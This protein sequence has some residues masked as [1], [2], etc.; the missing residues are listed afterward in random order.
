MNAKNDKIDFSETLFLPKTSFAMRAGL[1]EQ[2]PKIL[3][4]W[5][6]TN[7]YHQLRQQSQDRKK[8]ILHDGPPYANGHLHMGHALN[9]ILK[10]FVIRSQQMLGN[11]SSYIP[12]WDCHGLP[13]EW[14]IE[15]QYR[16]NG[17]N[18]D[19]V[20]IIQFR[21]ECRE[22][23]DK[24]IN[25]QR[26]EFIRLGINGDWFSPYTTMSY[27][28]ESIIVKEFFKFLE[29]ESLYRGSKPV[30]WSTV[31]KTALAEAEIEYKE[32]KST[33][34][35]VKFP[36][37]ECSDK[38]FQKAAVV[39]WTT[40]P[41]TIPGNRAIAYSAEINYS[42]Y[43]VESI[44][45]HS[46]LRV[47]DQIIFADE[48]LENVKTQCKLLDL[49]KISEVKDFGSFICDHPFRKSGY[50]F[51]VKLYD[52]DFVTLEQGTGFVHIAPGHG[53]DDYILGIANNIDVP[54][55]VDENGEYFDH[56]PLFNGK[57]IFNEDGSDA[58]ANIAVIIELKKHENLA[59]KGS[60]R[61]S[62][63]HSWRSKAPVIFRNTPQWFISMEKNQLRDKALKEIE[64][65]KWYPKQ[66]KN[67]IYSMIEERPDWVVS[68]QRAWGVPLSIFYNIKTGKPLV[69]KEMNDRI[70]ELYKKE[71]SDAWFKYSKEEL[72]GSK[73]NSNEFK[74]VDDILDV[75]FDS[76]CTHAFVLDGKD[77]QIWPASIYLEGTDQHRGWFHSSLLESCG[78]RGIAPYESVLT[79]GFILHED[80]LKMSKSSSNTV[81]PAEIIEK[82]GA[83]ILRLW[84]ASS[85][86]SEDLKIGPEIIKSNIDSYRR[87]RNTLRFI[88][89][90]LSDFTEK[91]KIPLNDLDELEL[92][93]LSEL[94]ILKKEVISNY[95]IFEFQKVFSSI[96]NFCTNDLSSFYFDIRKDTLYC[97]TKENKIR[98]STRTVLDIL[99]HNLISLLA[100]IL[101]FTSEEAWQSRFGSDTSIHQKDFSKLDG[102]LINKN[103]STKWETYKKLRKAINGAIEIKRKE[104]V[105]GSSLEAS[106]LLYCP[107]EE[108]LQ[109]EN[110][111]LENISIIS[112][113]KVVHD[114]PQNNCYIS[115]SDKNIGVY[116]S[117]V[118]G[119]KCERCWKYFTNLNNSICSRCED[120]ISCL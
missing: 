15:E 56:V 21:K 49:K 63:P 73:Y 44:A 34:I 84:V 90:N 60:L 79:H 81:S 72:L 31:E 75:W 13:I 46:T 118:N 36:V 61:H 22:F 94:E 91:E 117:K 12:G 114:K 110:E 28:A 51:D 10:D 76:G 96:F 93:I 83:D 67:R 2:E 4:G 55:T 35:C 87:L 66:G 85:D 40:T 62:Y 99:F 17:K 53:A 102:S 65:V 74:K 18:K 107:K 42:M 57:K 95:K 101:C 89:G 8:F 106:V 7:I 27:E 103:L 41:W 98:R 86:Y 25:I 30:M 97:D 45:E 105:L 113:L 43:K 38:S 16:E 29:N 68:R 19:D 50:N 58:D 48:L 92:Y 82:S 78:T 111:I 69:D 88:L 54:D 116:V 77:D 64:K 5:A 59:G 32:H 20:D 120:A 14:K 47:G 71:G 119:S 108:A 100:P 24:W 37:R 109:I 6:K 9:K 104:K 3:D 23:A 80:G 1:P 112:E 26:E 39:I 115:E 52:A 11:D 70:I 33:T